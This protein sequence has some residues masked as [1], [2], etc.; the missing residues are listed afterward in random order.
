MVREHTRDERLEIASELGRDGLRH[1]WLVA[2]TAWLRPL[3]A[4]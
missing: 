1:R 3:G 2:L 4:A